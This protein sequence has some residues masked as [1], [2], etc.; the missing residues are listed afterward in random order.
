M[1]I[2]RR[3]QEESSAERELGRAGRKKEHRVGGEGSRGKVEILILEREGG[4]PLGP[5]L[6]LSLLGDSHPL[7]QTSC[8][9][10]A[11]RHCQSHRTVKHLDQCPCQT[12]KPTI[13]LCRIHSDKPVLIKV[14]RRP[15][16]GSPKVLR[17]SRM[18]VIQLRT[19]L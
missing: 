2:G 8:L 1:Q 16:Q 17:K 6:A 7:S 14:T 15:E 9:L 3:E 18:S 19:E 12:A 5:S 4:V 11:C 10:R 13:D